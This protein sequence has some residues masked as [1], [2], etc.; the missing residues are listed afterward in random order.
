MNYRKAW[1]AVGAVGLAMGALGCSSGR[2]V[3]VSGKISAPS[4]V[5]LGSKLAVDFIDV[6]GEGETAEKSVAHSMEL[7]APG[8]FK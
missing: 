8:D 1:L 7:Q 4:T 2:D 6:V 3:E 5:T